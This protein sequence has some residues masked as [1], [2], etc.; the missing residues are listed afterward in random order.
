MESLNL[1]MPRLRGHKL[2][3]SLSIF[4]RACQSETGG[5]QDRDLRNPGVLGHHRPWMNESKQSLWRRCFQFQGDK[6][7]S[8]NQRIGSGAPKMP[9][10]SASRHIGCPLLPLNKGVREC[11]GSSSLS[12]C[13][14]TERGSNAQ[15]WLAVKHLVLTSGNDTC[16]TLVLHN[17]ASNPQGSSYFHKLTKIAA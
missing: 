3:S 16:P 15:I 7:P 4:E 8:Q 6:K 2:D 10:L 12:C 9:R 17:W 1:K 11:V 5:K 13:S 14:Q